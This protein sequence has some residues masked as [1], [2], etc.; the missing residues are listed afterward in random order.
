MNDVDTRPRCVRCNGI[1]D[2][3]GTNT[4]NSPKYCRCVCRWPDHGCHQ[5]IY[6]LLNEN[7]RIQPFDYDG[8]PHHATCRALKAARERGRRESR[9]VGV[10]PLESFLK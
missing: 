9:P 4:L 1:V 7:E 2:P 6:F 10:G 5:P 8:T 3:L